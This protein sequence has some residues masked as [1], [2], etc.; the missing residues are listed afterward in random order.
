MRSLCYAGIAVLACLLADI[1]D[2]NGIDYPT[3][4]VTSL[5]EWVG[6]EK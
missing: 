4:T 3:R 5:S 1:S 6:A 2:A